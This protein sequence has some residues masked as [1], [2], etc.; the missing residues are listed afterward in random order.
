MFYCKELSILGLK[1]QVINNGELKFQFKEGLNEL[2]LD[3]SNFYDFT[4]FMNFLR[5]IICKEDWFKIAES[6]IENIVEIYMTFCNTCTMKDSC[7]S[8]LINNKGYILSENLIIDGE[9]SI[10]VDL[11]DIEIGKG[12]IGNE[13]EM[14]N[15]LNLYYEQKKGGKLEKSIVKTIIYDHKK[16][17][18]S[19]YNY[20]FY[21]FDIIDLYREE[22]NFQFSNNVLCKSREMLFKS[23]PSE[24]IVEI[25]PDFSVISNSKENK[26]VRFSKEEIGTGYKLLTCFYPY[27]LQKLTYG[28]TLILSEKFAGIHPILKESIFEFF[29][30][31]NSKTGGIAQLCLLI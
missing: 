17:I 11:K 7:Y 22:P 12:F 31:E 25:L 16:N 30:K 14:D 23:F 1:E 27:L 28:G 20:F 6:S 5:K 21:K 19:F 13:I 18:D 29:E 9:L 2:E 24:G 26:V 8:M 4:Y 3:I 15:I 10:S